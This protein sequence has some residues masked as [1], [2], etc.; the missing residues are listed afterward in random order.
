MNYYLGIDPGKFGGIAI[1]SQDLSEAKGVRFP[2]D[3]VE[4]ANIVREWRSKHNITLAAI[5]KVGA[6][7]KQGVTSMFNFGQNF[8]AWQGILAALGIPFIFV[9]PHKWQKAMLDSGGGTTKERSLNM[10]RRFFP[11]VEMKYKA[12]DG[13]ADALHLARFVK[14]YL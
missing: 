12:D 5:E 8:G 9:T 13:I 11:C 10:A 4:A 2:G 3:F 7:P 6:M 1:I 14:Q